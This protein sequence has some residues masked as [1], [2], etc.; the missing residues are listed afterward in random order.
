MTL[1]RNVSK[2]GDF[3][4]WGEGCGGSGARTVRLTPG[5]V[6]GGCYGWGEAGEELGVGAVDGG[7][8]DEGLGRGVSRGD[9]GPG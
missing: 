2:K 9:G 1:A 8:V 5:A 4:F 3:S 6:L 7:V